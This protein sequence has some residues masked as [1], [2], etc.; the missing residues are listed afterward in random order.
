[1]LDFRVANLES[2]IAQLERMG[3]KVERDPDVH[4]HGR[5]AGFQDPKGNPVALWQ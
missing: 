3:V 4:P 5:F 1:M 2:M